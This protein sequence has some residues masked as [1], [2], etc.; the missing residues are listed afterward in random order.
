MLTKLRMDWVVCCGNRLK[1]VRIVELGG[2]LREFLYPRKN[3][4]DAN[5]FMLT[6]TRNKGR[7][8][9]RRGY[10]HVN[11]IAKSALWVLFCLIVASLAVAQTYTITDL[12]VL[13]GDTASASIG[14]NSSGQIVGCSDTSTTYYPC[15]GLSPGH[16][17]LWKSKTGMKDLGALHGDDTSGG[18][19]INE[20]DEVVG[21]SK[22]SQNVYHTF[23]WTKK[24]GM[25]ALRKLPGGTTNSASSI[26][27]TGLIVGA[28]DS[29]GS[30]L[31]RR[32]LICHVSIVN[33]GS[34]RKGFLPLSNSPDEP[35]LL[36][37]KNC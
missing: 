35:E 7:L 21:F 31:L 22:N 33:V 20:S 1:S 24:T 2:M 25:I 26:N 8:T 16:A 14:I 27:A 4:L 34:R 12:G 28:S 15:S 17:F 5:R 11:V 18:V 9:G 13:H 36:G 19:G 30:S 6:G 10:K 32:H 3:G 29:R 37:A 23:L